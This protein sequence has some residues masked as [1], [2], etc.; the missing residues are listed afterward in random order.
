MPAASHIRLAIVG[1]SKESMSTIP[2]DVCSTPQ[3]LTPVLAGN[4]SVTPAPGQS[5]L[6]RNSVIIGIGASAY[7]ATVS[8]ATHSLGLHK[9]I[10]AGEVSVHRFSGLVVFDGLH[11]KVTSQQM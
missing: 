6:Y 3:L 11:C 4:C 1:V 5:G 10:D 2:L 8:A 9:H 7:P